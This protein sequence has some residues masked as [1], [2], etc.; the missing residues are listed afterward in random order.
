MLLYAS[1]AMSQQP[2]SQGKVQP[3]TVDTLAYPSRLWISAQSLASGPLL[4]EALE[5]GALIFNSQGHVVAKVP[6]GRGAG[7]LD[8]QG[9]Y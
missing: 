4:F 7:A 5:R 6:V 8:Q 3:S 1:A 2:A 9:D